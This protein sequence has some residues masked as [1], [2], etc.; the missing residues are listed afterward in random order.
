ME[1][2]HS[3][4]LLAGLAQEFDRELAARLGPRAW[5][6]HTEA[7]SLVVHWYGAAEFGDGVSRMRRGA[8][9]HNIPFNHALRAQIRPFTW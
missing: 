6:N 7:C 8:T 3:A 2:V 1:S 5:I 9:G 4:R